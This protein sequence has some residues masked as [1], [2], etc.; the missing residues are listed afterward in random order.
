M[1]TFLN[2]LLIF[3]IC[4]VSFGVDVNYAPVSLESDTLAVDTSIKG[5]SIISYDKLTPN[6]KVLNFVVHTE[7][8]ASYISSSKFLFKL[9]VLQNDKVIKSVDVIP[10]EGELP[11]EYLIKDTMDYKIDISNETLALADGQ[12]KFKLSS[13][14]SEDISPYEFTANYEADVK[15][16]AAL[17]EAPAGKSPLTVYVPSKDYKFSVPVTLMNESAV[18]SVPKMAEAMKRSLDPKYGLATTPIIGEYNYVVLK[19]KTIFIDVKKSDSLY[20]Q[21]SA[22]SKGIMQSYVNTFS[23]YYP[24]TPIRFL[25]DY[26]RSKDYFFGEDISKTIA[27]NHENEALLLLKDK[28]KSYLVPYKVA[29]INNSEPIQAKVDKMI[30]ALKAGSQSLVASLNGNFKYQAMTM[31]DGKLQITLA[32]DAKLKDYELDALGFSLKNLAGVNSVELLK[33]GAVLK[34][35]NEKTLINPLQ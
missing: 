4:L 33:E 22:L 16:G 17:A 34:L 10:Y 21:E 27:T 18:S 25:V 3:A 9:D 2:L 7:R 15:Y 26:K 19:N 12:Y 6:P 28:P 30:D 32:D 31:A 11:Y 35:Y 24:N 29:A 23:H 14:L 20:S 1:R 13:Y 5:V 8:E